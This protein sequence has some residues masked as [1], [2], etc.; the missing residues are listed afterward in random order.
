MGIHLIIGIKQNAEANLCLFAGRLYIPTSVIIGNPLTIQLKAEFYDSAFV[1]V[2]F[3]AWFI[4]MLY[5]KVNDMIFPPGGGMPIVPSFHIIVPPKFLGTAYM[6]L[7]AHNSKLY[8][9][10]MTTPK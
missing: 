5:P 3:L 7:K 2:V 1:D 9:K 4:K 10:K 6:P 8:I